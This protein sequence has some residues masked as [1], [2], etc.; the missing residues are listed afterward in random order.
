MYGPIKSESIERIPGPET[1]AWGANR[2][3]SN[4]MLKLELDLDLEL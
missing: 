2:K 3:L 1:K 4:W